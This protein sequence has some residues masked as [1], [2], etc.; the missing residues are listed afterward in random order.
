MS[1][2]NHREYFWLVMHVGLSVHLH[3]DTPSASGFATVAFCWTRLRAIVCCLVQGWLAASDHVAATRGW[4]GGGVG[5]CPAGW[6]YAANQCDMDSKSSY[7]RPVCSL[8]CEHVRQH[9]RWADQEKD[10]KDKLISS[11]FTW[12]GE[13]FIFTFLKHCRISYMLE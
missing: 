1:G 13:S 9:S 4:G 5:L 2:V 7:A 12:R 10:R 11:P 8:S 6:I 3:I